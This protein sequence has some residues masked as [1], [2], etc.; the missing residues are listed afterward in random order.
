MFHSLLEA[1]DAGFQVWDRTV[2]GYLVRR[3]E[4]HGWAFAEVHI[5]A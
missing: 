2:Y 4:S 5:A 1:L 3:R